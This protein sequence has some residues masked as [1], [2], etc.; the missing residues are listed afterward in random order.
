MSAEGIIMGILV[1]IGIIMCIVAVIAA[2]FWGLMLLWAV[3]LFI[4]GLGLII[5]VF[6]AYFMLL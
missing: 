5:L 3:I 2:M 4:G 6:I 1:L